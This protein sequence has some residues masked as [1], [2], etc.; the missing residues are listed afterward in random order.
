MDVNALSNSESLAISLVIE[1]EILES[2]LFYSLRHI[3]FIVA[4]IFLVHQVLLERYQ[5]ILQLS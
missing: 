5:V 4:H 2:F 3:V 1:W